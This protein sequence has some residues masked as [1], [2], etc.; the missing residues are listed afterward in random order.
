MVDAALKLQTI[1]NLR[2]QILITTVH[3]IC[4][5]HHFTLIPPNSYTHK[6]IH[7]NS[8]QFLSLLSHYNYTVAYLLKARTVEAEKQP[9]LGNARRNN[10]GGVMICDAY[11]HYYGVISQ[12]RTW[13][14]TPT[15]EVFP[16]AFSVDPLWGYMTRPTKYTSESECSAVE[17]A[18][19]RC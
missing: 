7:P 10:R 19:V 12:A 5:L 16:A 11:S 2:A 13:C 4:T 1:D 18:V 9:L 8:T 14:H 3:L 6:F 15:E 17:D